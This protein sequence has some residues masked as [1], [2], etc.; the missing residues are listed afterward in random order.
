MVEANPQPAR[1]LT[2]AAVSSKNL[3]GRLAENLENHEQWIRRAARAGARFVGFPEA[4]LTGYVRDA[5]AAIRLNSPPVRHVAELAARHRIFVAVGFNERRGR[6]IYNTCAVLGPRGLAGIMRK[7]NCIPAESNFYT[8]GRG[9]TVIDVA[10]WKFGVAICADASFYEMFRIP[11]LRGAHAL[12]APHA[13]T[14]QSLGN[15][16]GGWKRWRLETWPRFLP[17]C[18]LFVVACNSAGLSERPESDE[19]ELAFCGGALI[20]GPDGKVL[21]SSR[22]RRKTECMAVATL[23]PWEWHPGPHLDCIRPDILYGRKDGWA[24][25]YGHGPRG[26][27]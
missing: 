6:L 8:S 22:A 9:I 17:D 14:L 5:A 3:P 11:A 27:K 7:I 18:R 21:S 16:P 1:A 19:E 10:G 26:R 24:H 15:S 2:V 20:L 12:F 23:N 4:S 25:G 13:N